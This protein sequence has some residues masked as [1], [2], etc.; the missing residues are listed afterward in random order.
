LYF[1][2]VTF[3]TLGFGDIHAA[4]STGAIVISIQV[5]IGYIFLGGLVAM[6]SDKLARRAG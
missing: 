1:S 3:T 5:I 4:T 6:L 2:L